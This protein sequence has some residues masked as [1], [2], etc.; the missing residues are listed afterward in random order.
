MASPVPRST[1]GVAAEEARSAIRRYEERLSRDPESLAWA[2]LADAY[3]KAGR[4]QEAIA[5]CRAGL[6]RFPHST[7][8]RLILARAQID[9]GLL[10]E[11]RAELDSILTA[12]PQDAEAHR[13]VGELHLRTGRWPEARRHLV[14]AVDL[15]PDDRET[16]HLLDVM[17]GA[18]H[19]PESSP[20]AGVLA[21]DRFATP[22][23]AEVCL[24]QGLV[25]EA[26]QICLRI[27]R[28]DPDDTRA[29]AVLAQ[30]LRARAPRRRGG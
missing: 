10:D 28:A 26:T 5:L 4:A 23:F 27:L 3:R 7:T 29:R 18:G 14:A 12:S 19:V 9:G 20:L 8:A 16:R 6:A 2:P 24:D 11:A 17:T 1:G 30:A 15:Q 22:T 13:L 21:D 25:D